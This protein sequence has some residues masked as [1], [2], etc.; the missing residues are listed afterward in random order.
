MMIPVGGVAIVLARPAAESAAIEALEP[1]Q[2]T[3]ASSGF[4]ATRRASP[5]EVR[6]Y[7]NDMFDRLDRDG[8]GFVD[9]AEAPRR[10]VTS[11]R[12]RDGTVGQLPL[13]Q[14]EWIAQ[15]DADRDGQVSR[16]EYFA[17]LVPPVQAILGVPADW[18]PRDG[19]APVRDP[20]DRPG[21]R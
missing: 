4:E 6:A 19:E 5:G 8:S 3:G 9:P 11:F 10:Q 16:A 1:A 17:H 7:L 20:L 12:A 14:A 15:G 13:T 2:G 18:S 21:A